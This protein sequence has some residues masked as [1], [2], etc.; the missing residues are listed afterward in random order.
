MTIP[1]LTQLSL[2]ANPV[3]SVQYNALRALTDLNSD[4]IAVLQEVRRSR[5]PL[6]RQAVVALAAVA[7]WEAVEPA[8]QVLIERLIRLTTPRRPPEPV[9]WADAWFAVRS[10]DQT[11]I[12]ATLG[13]ANA[14]P[15]ATW[16]INE[17]FVTLETECV[18]I[19]PCLD[20]WTLVF[21]DLP[22]PPVTAVTA[23]SHR[24]GAAQ[25]YYVFEGVN[26]WAIAEHGR[27]IRYY[28]SEDADR[29][30]GPPHPAEQGFRLPHDDLSADNAFVNLS[31]MP[32]A[33][34]ERATQLVGDRSVPD[35]CWAYDIAHRLSVDPITVG[36]HTRV[37]GHGLIAAN[38][39]G[40]L[41]GIRPI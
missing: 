19:T 27:I 8:D 35:R 40:Q 37:E 41:R 25:W 39:N 10:G 36:S 14:M 5:S 30:L 28:D 32:G 4:A 13:I 7:G 16:R 11:A 15:V 20:G 24:F 3:E 21:G 17:A 23:L 29:R 26:G 34:E 38:W 18:Y 9:C 2:L 33:T 6:R 31:T 12:L 22:T 1:C